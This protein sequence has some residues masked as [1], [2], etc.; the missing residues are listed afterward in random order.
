M[1]NQYFGFQAPSPGL[2][3]ATFFRDKVILL[4]GEQDEFI[5]FWERVCTLAG[6]ITR[7]VNEEDM[8]TTGAI[9]LV[10]E[11]DCPHEVQ[12]MANQENVPLVSTTWV[13]QCLIEAR[14]IPPT[15]HDRFSFMYLEPE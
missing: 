6:A 8:N 15:S 14:V 1:Q 10:T 13:V 4:C 9:A 2:R 5:K 11:W 3:N 12:N 7:V